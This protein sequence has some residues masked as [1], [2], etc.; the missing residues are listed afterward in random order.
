ML[1]LQKA[2]QRWETEFTASSLALALA[3]STFFHVFT[4][5]RL[6][7]VQSVW[8]CWAPILRMFMLTPL[9]FHNKYSITKSISGWLTSPN[10]SCKCPFISQLMLVQVLQCVI[11]LHI[12]A[13]TVF[14]RRFLYLTL[15]ANVCKMHKMFYMLRTCMHRKH[16]KGIN[17]ITMQHINHT[18]ALYCHLVVLLNI[19]CSKIQYV[20]NN[21]EAIV[22]WVCHLQRQCRGSTLLAL[23]KKG[24][25]ASK[26]IMLQSWTGKQNTY[27]YQQQAINNKT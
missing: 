3:P 17:R 8:T 12:R 21:G 16:R 15:N 13:M 22:K 18:V 20:D 24:K 23:A 26:V 2:V 11:I 19:T 4:V 14:F 5:R 10:T 9:A 7:Y 1:F 27:K 25:K 6:Q